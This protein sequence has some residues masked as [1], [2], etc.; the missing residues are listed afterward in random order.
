VALLGTLVAAHWWVAGEK[1]FA[2]SLVGLC[3]CLA[4]PL[5]W[6]HHYV[7]ILPLGAVVV[8]RRSLP[9]WVRVLGGIWVVWVSLC[10]PLAVLPYAYN[11]ERTYDAVQQVVANLG[12][13]LGVALIIGLA[14]RL[15]RQ[16]RPPQSSGP[17]T[18]GAPARSQPGTVG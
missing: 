11:V 10:L 5:S 7:W 2:V 4:S 8:L 13:A 9:R 1:A 18:S 12:P 17:E 16:A 15:V 3:T 14:W 6:T